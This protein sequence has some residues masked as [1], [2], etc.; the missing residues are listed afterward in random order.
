M[1]SQRR[2]KNK[3]EAIKNSDENIVIDINQ[4]EDC[5]LEYFS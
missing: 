4:I 2:K 3:I 5:F 1:A